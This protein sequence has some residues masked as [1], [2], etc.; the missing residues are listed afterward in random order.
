MKNIKIT[1]YITNYNY[2]LYIEK[3]I[4]SV[5]NQDISDFEILI[6]DD[7]STDNSIEI[8]NKYIGDPRIKL[9]KQKN[10]GLTVS[11]N[12]A[13]KLAKGDYIMRLDADD[14]LFNYSLNALSTELDNNP[15]VGMVFGDYFVIDEQENI[16]EHFKRH[17][18]KK[19]VSLFDQP[20]HGACTMFR[21]KCLLKLGGYDE[22]INRQ[23]GYELW[24]R[25][26]EKYKV[27]NINRPIFNYR[28]HDKNLTSKEDL[29]LDTRTDILKRHAQR[30]NK[31]KLNGIAI[32]PIRGS[33]MDSRSLPFSKVNGVNL[34]DRTINFILDFKPIDKLIIS[35]PDNEVL[36][37]VNTKWGKNVVLIKRPSK[38]SLINSSI[39]PVINHI[40]YT[41]EIYFDYDYFILQNIESPFKNYKV[42]ESGINIMKIFDV[43]TVIGVRPMKDLLFNHDGK[44]MQFTF[45]QSQLR[46]ERNEI[47]KM[48]S[49]YLVRNISSY[50]ET[51]QIFG[52]SIGH[53]VFDQKSSFSIRSD[54]D[55]IIA[56]ALES[57]STTDK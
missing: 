8:I 35:T 2:S 31:T 16:L 21:K 47:Y 11:N 32:L 12:I 48:V 4:N 20:A 49:G 18:F 46:L 39:D 1:V 14:F 55:L 51:S 3:S 41:H 24:L 42:I 25:F 29:L 22:S 26:I 9:I 44:G 23:D 33:S 34:I 10:K 45:E 37:Y 40:F 17:N 57:K 13:L 19:D 56:N 30:K 52:K 6:I 27:L 28:Q 5:L 15:D 7:G 53:V 43:D 36:D 50:K 54:L 38:L